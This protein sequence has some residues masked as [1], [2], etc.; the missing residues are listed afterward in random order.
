MDFI[1]AAALCVIAICMAFN[2]P[3]KLEITQKYVTPPEPPEPVLSPEDKEA[4]RQSAGLTET[5]NRLNNIMLGRDDEE[6]DKNGSD[7]N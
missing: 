3:L 2:R 6:A 1:I 4:L 5:I 7:T